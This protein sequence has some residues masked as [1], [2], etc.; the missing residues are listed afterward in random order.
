MRGDQRVYRHVRIPVELDDWAQEY[1]DEADIS[2]NR[3]VEKALR[4]YRA[5]KE[6]PA[7]A[8]RAA[9]PWGLTGSPEQ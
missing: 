9:K 1:A 2:L 6:T 7:P 4:M 5:S 3:L 8:A